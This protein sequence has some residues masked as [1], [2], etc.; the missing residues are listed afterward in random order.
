MHKDDYRG[1]RDLI[2]SELEIYVDG[3][4]RFTTQE[5]SL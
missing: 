3:T 4:K 5:G 2:L 1:L